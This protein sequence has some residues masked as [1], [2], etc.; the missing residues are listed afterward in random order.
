MK[1]VRDIFD[2]I[3]SVGGFML[4]IVG[5][6]VY[7]LIQ[8]SEADDRNRELRQKQTAYCYTQNM[9]VVETDAGLYCGSPS[10]LKIIK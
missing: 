5:L 2:M 3:F 8:V 10:S 7:T 4:L 6:F 9:V 1:Y